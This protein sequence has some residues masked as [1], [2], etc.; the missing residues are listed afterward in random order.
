M[1]NLL[2]P[3]QFC[4]SPESVSLAA[5]EEL[6][7][8]ANSRMRLSCVMTEAFAF[9]P[10]L[11]LSTGHFATPRRDIPWWEFRGCAMPESIPGLGVLNP[12]FDQAERSWYFILPP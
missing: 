12:A 7:H 4:Q 11:S 3:T 9:R 10:R 8:F 2:S 6:T 1:S 5:R